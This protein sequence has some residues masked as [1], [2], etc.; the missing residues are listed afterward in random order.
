MLPDLLKPNTHQHSEQ[1]IP[2]LQPP[3]NERYAPYSSSSRP[4]ALACPG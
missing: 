3:G 4:Q 1:D 2:H